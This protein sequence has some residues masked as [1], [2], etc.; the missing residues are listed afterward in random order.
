MCSRATGWLMPEPDRH[1]LDAEDDEPELH[2]RWKRSTHLGVVRG[3][4]TAVCIS[5]RSR[6]DARSAPDRAGIQATP[7]RAAFAKATNVAGADR[8]GLAA[9]MFA[10]NEAIA[11]SPAIRRPAASSHAR[12]LPV[13]LTSHP[14]VAS[15][16]Q[17]TRWLITVE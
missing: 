17:R 7:P 14:L 3:W 5:C 6:K 8:A 12:A 16:R 1:S 9:D 15:D 11:V 13:L 2:F 10:G 4:A